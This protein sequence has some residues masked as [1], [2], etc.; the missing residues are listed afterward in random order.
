MSDKLDFPD[1]QS[2][3]PILVIKERVLDR[4]LLFAAILA[5]LAFIIASFIS[6]TYGFSPGFYTD[7][8]CLIGLYVVYYFREKAPLRFKLSAIIVFVFVLFISS[9]VQYGTVSTQLTLSILIPF[10]TILAYNLR[11]TLIVMAGVILSFGIIAFLY[12]NGTIESRIENPLND[13]ITL[14]TTTGIVILVSSSI[15]VLMMNRYNEEMIGIVGKLKKRDK[16]LVGHLEEKTVMIQEI[17]HRVKNNLAVVSGLLELQVLNIDDPDLQKTMQKSVNRILSIA[18]VHEKLYQSEDFNKIPFKEYVDDLSNVILASMNSERLDITFESEIETEFLS[19]NK[20]VP[21]G[22]IFNELITNSIK[23]GFKPDKDN[24]IL[25]S[26]SEHEDMIH[27]TYSDNGVGIENFEEAASSSLGFSIIGSLLSQ[28]KADYS[29][30]TQ[31]GF[32]LSFSFP[33]EI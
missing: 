33:S 2:W 16:E 29:Y 9:L 13:L 25:I 20:G 11:V 12:I 24:R 22:I 31:N 18:K 6:P 30:E 32:K 26:I 19:I 8:V 28:I 1:I 15:I 23:Y 17:H 7:I 27:A 5:S 4:S 10:L 14:W 3:E 21:I